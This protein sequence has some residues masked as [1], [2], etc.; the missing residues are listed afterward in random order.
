MFIIKVLLILNNFILQNIYETKMMKKLSEKI[1]IVVGKSG[2]LFGI[3]M[4]AGL[5]IYYLFGIKE[6]PLKMNILS[7]RNYQLS[8]SNLVT[9]G[10]EY[11]IFLSIPSD[12]FYSFFGRM[13]HI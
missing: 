6:M 11:S 4:I 5:L 1:K 8:V 2:I 3:F 9:N 13:T 7:A 12:L 10:T